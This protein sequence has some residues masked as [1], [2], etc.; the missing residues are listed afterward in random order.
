MEN[1]L[2]LTPK[3]NAVIWCLQNGW[4]IIASSESSWVTICNKDFEYQITSALFWRLAER[5][6]LIHQNNYRGLWDWELTVKG[7][8]IKT[9]PVS[10]P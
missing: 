3:Q 7:Q 8:N 10:F 4:E 5:H 6:E 2:K 9:K 1:K